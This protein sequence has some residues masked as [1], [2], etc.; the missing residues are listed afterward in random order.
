MR[1]YI[2]TY[3]HTE[4]SFCRLIRCQG[5]FSER[6]ISRHRGLPRQTEGQ[7]FGDPLI[8][9][10]VS[11]AP[12][13]VSEFSLYSALF[14][15]FMTRV[16]YNLEQIVSIYSC[17]VKTNSYKSC[18]TKFRRK[19]PN[20]CPSGYTTSKLVQKIRNHDILIDRKP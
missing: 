11:V 7:S 1:A 14:C 3:I 9:E 4:C 5:S 19:F 16:R 8:S 13:I 6:L 10:S 15:V 2:H 20:T 18:S 17:Y 12:S